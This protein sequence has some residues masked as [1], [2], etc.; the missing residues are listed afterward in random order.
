MKNEIISILGNRGISLFGISEPKELAEVPS[1]FS[2]QS[3][4]K[5]CRSVFCY[6]VPIPKGILHAEANC[7]PLFWRFS[8]ITYRFLDTVSNEICTVLEAHGH[9]AAPIYSCFP[10]KVWEKKFYGLLPLAYLAQECGIGKLTRAGLVGNARF[11]TRLLLGGLITSAALELTA[12]APDQPC[13]SDC[14]LCRQSCPPAAIDQDGRVDHNLCVR[15]SGANPL[16]T[17]LLADREI[18]AKFG[19]DTLL[20]TVG[21]DDH[22]MYTCSRCLEVC[23]L[24]R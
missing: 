9:L 19:F 7:S 20:N 17:H 21:V 22:G 15:Y 1:Q 14:F 6:A 3:I 12:T 24:N 2:A 23:P 18:K 16:L 4:L 13:P 5:Y 11:G 10:W 8:N